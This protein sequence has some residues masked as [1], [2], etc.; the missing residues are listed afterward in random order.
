[1]SR[2]LRGVRARAGSLLAL[3]A[4]TSVVV[5]GSMVVLGFARAAG[6]S[7]ALVVPLLLLGLLAVPASG[8]E[9]AAARRQEIGVAR[10]RGSTGPELVR[11]VLPEPMLAIAIGTV[12]G[13]P[14]GTWGTRA[15]TAY[16]L[17]EAAGPGRAALLAALAVAAVGVVAVYVGMRRTVVE[18]LPHQLTSGERPRRATTWSAFGALFWLVAA[19]VALYRSGVAADDPDGLTLAGPALVGLA[20]GQ[21][22]VWTIA[23]TSRLLVA[24]TSHRSTS[25]WL[26]ARRLRRT[27]DIAGPLRLL[28]AATVVA[29][30]ALAGVSAVH[31]WTDDT[32]RLQT[33]GSTRVPMELGAGPALALTDRLDPAGRWLMAGVS[34][35]EDGA[36][37]GRRTFLDLGRLE[38]VA[39]NGLAG[40]PAAALPGR[41]ALALGDRPGDAGRHAVRG[42]TLTVAI[43]GS[44][45]HRRHQGVLVE[46]SY[47]T[48]DG[49]VG[50]VG[51]FVPS[52]PP[53]PGR[54]VTAPVAD[55]R[56][57]CWVSAVEVTRAGFF[58]V[59][60]ERGERSRERFTGGNAG[61]LVVTRLD[62]G[63]HDLLDQ[64]WVAEGDGSGS[65]PAGLFVRR[66]P[67]NG[68]AF[69]PEGAGLPLD[70]LETTGL[71]R[72]EESPAV[73]TPGGLSRPARVVGHLDAL[74]LVGTA[75]QLGDLRAA[76]VGDQPTVPA[77]EVF[78]VAAAD[79]PQALLDRVVRAG[80]HDPVS[81]SEE[82]AA[83]ARSS[84]AEQA[85]VFVL[86]SLACLAVA[87]VV[88]VSAGAR[89]RQRQRVEVAALRVV[90]VR[91]E[92]IRW[93]ARL[94]LAVQ[95]LAAVVVGLLGGV[96]ATQVLLAHLPV[97]RLSE[98]ALPLRAGLEPFALLVAG[99]ACA[100]ALLAVGSRVRS[101]SPE[102]TAPARLREGD[103]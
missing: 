66:T 70:V 36:E 3:C 32:A 90:G 50:S 91:R 65:G 64:D 72:G 15:A 13:V 45:D 47:V 71:E 73:S 48:D 62:L 89:Q 103:G 82:S 84:G 95:T 60:N 100:A 9:L 41:V 53:G 6:T 4:M 85:P 33:I 51:T 57:G 79:T 86:M 68:L 63:G 59:E 37:A 52:H 25:A 27:A 20:A 28:V 76:V 11:L 46:V 7:W 80:G 88:L 12:V 42:R 16:W 67:D 19:G 5:A 98:H 22:A 18:P 87:I 43:S 56:R 94:E 44:T 30:V 58:T 99:G 39:G 2:I 93:A 17:G 26:A 77:G 10:L 38:T 21:L 40:T 92:D 31:A 34:V 49:Y 8:Q 83:V 24:R 55:C 81:L 35:Q 75:G 61:P 96:L 78:V 14:V 101:V 54:P 29:T 23:A 102:R 1:M 74:P 69:V 97:L